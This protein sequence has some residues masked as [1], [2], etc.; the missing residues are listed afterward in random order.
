MS[1]VD[2]LVVLQYSHISRLKVVTASPI[3]RKR[4]ILEILLV[5][6]ALVML[7]EV[8]E[9]W[10]KCFCVITTG[11]FNCILLASS[12]PSSWTANNCL[13]TDYLELTVFIASLQLVKNGNMFHVCRQWGQS[14]ISSPVRRQW[15]E[16]GFVSHLSPN[17]WRKSQWW[18][19]E[20]DGKSKNGAELIKHLWPELSVL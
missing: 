20:I 1:R 4:R 17:I 14:G 18:Q 13:N 19:M 6:I 15:G 12:S 8:G 11:N 3:L 16:S 10:V 9:F 2:I 7:W 5:E